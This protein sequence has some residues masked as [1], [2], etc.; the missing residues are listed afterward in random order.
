MALGTLDTSDSNISALAVWN[1]NVERLIDTVERH[2]AALDIWSTLKPGMR[3]TLKPNLL[4]KRTPDTATTTHPAMIDAVA[5]VLH[6][7]DITDITLAD[8]PGG[9]YT[10]AQLE[11][12]YSACGM[13]PVADRLDIKLNIDTDAAEIGS[14]TSR[15]CRSFNIINPVHEADFVINLPK[16]K[17]HAM[18]TMSGAVKNLFGCV[19]G[20]QKPEFHFRFPEIEDFSR[21]LLD[22]SQIVAPGVT[23]VDAVV[24]M[25]GDGPSAGKPRFT[26]MTF[27]SRNIYA[28][29]LALA[30]YIGLAPEEVR[31][32][33]L[34]IA[35]GLC[36]PDASGLTWVSGDP[37]ATLTDFSH[38]RSKPLSFTDHLHPIFNK[39]VNWLE[40]NLL[41]PRPVVRKRNCIGCHK[42]VESCSPNAIVLK[43][44]KAVIDYS[45]CIRCYCCH[46]MCP[47]STIYIR[48]VKLLGI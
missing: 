6:N 7:H 24:S 38:P 47:V 26:G 15:I 2:F 28:L 12:I 5:T 1:Y 23:I 27:A 14:E 18:T 48:K 46:E 41:S 43:N 44:G 37:P 4:M 31:T 10:R 17:T 39:P 35:D 20:L 9:P 36:P 11:A 29:D 21:M 33:A 32:V 30:N 34:S 22:L 16:L 8:S 40:K 3:V 45:K 13:R 19:P 42:C 25:E